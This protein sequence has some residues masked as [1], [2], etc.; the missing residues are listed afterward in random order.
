MGA[1]YHQVLT[2]QTTHLICSTAKGLKY[3]AA[4][5]PPLLGCVK[6][7]IPEYVRLCYDTA[8]RLDEARYLTPILAGIRVSIS[9]FGSG[10]DALRDLVVSAGGTYSPSLNEGS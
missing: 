1:T 8:T 7:V 5:R 4:V 2:H 3:E 10:R 6:L 9:G